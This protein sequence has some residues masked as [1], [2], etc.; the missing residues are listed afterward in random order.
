MEWGAWCCHCL[1]WAGRLAEGQGGL[2]TGCFCFL[3]AV[4][5]GPQ[6]SVPYRSSCGETYA[7]L[8]IPP[9]PFD[10]EWAMGTGNNSKSVQYR[11]E[12]AAAVTGPIWS[13]GIS[14]V[15]I[16]D[17]QAFHHVLLLPS[18]YP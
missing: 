9:F 3:S 13:F 15:L 6:S 1:G 5:R 8:P 10:L 16:G 4:P 7:C 17:A 14:R 18:V 2:D 12:G 11:C